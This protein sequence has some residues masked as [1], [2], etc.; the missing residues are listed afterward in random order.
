MYSKKEAR[1]QITEAQRDISVGLL[2]VL[3]ES[4]HQVEAD[5]QRARKELGIKECKFNKKA[6]EVISRIIS[7]ID[8]LYD[9]FPPPGHPNYKPPN[10]PV[11][12]P[13]DTPTTPKT[14]LH[15]PQKRKRHCG[16]SPQ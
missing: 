16:S 12:N 10:A 13:P 2:F 9:P 11:F 1:K 7:E 6:L 14:S 4:L 8:W 5:E 3:L 15:L